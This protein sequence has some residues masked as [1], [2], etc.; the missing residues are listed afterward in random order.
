MLGRRD[1][2]EERHRIMSSSCYSRPE[3]PADPVRST[4]PAT[5]KTQRSS[6]SES[7]KALLL[8]KGSR[9]D[10]CSQISAVERLCKVVTPATNQNVPLLTPPSE[11]MQVKPTS[12][13]HTLDRYDI[14]AHLTLDVP[15][16]PT[17]LCSQNLSV[18]LGL[19][20]RDLMS[21]QLF[22]LSSSM[23]PRSLTP[24]CSASRRFA[25]RRR[26]VAAPMTA[27]FEGECE[28]EE[29]EEDK[30]DVSLESPGI[31]EESS[32]RLVEIS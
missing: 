30:D 31:K 12:L 2:E 29:E 8:R 18:M 23:R 25:A 9:S 27:I 3:T 10:L 28:E 17:S 15:V 21:T 24:P 19:R 14:S 16:S 13:F 5:F 32:Q 22:F 26:F 7:F 1:S 11:Q 20:Q 6:R 4:R